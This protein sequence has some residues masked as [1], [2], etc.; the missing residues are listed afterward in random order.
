MALTPDPSTHYTDEWLVLRIVKSSAVVTPQTT[1]NFNERHS[2]KKK[3]EKKLCSAKI[4]TALEKRVV[5]LSLSVGG[6]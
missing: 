2:L 3:R 6:A 1:I 4:T 5:R